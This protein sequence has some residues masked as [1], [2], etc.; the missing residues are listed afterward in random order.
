MTAL[1]F[2]PHSFNII[3]AL[4]ATSDTPWLSVCERLTSLLG[5][6]DKVA[7]QGL[8]ALSLGRGL[9]MLVYLESRGFWIS[10]LL[11][12][13]TFEWSIRVI[14]AIGGIPRDLSTRVAG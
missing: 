8:L 11:N 9:G 3:A 12:H 6:V 2:W 14:F 1:S 4:A 13:G 10:A 5:V 7:I